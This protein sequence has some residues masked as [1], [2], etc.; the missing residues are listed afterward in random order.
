MLLDQS[1]G[2][3]PEGSKIPGLS[4][5]REQSCSPKCHEVRC[6]FALGNLILF[7]RTAVQMP[8]HSN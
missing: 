1:A 3:D 2:I 6:A 7:H 5:C 8:T 4:V